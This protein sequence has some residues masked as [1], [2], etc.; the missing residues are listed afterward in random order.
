MNMQYK[1]GTG[2]VAAGT[3]VEVGP[4]GGIVDGGRTV[5]MKA[6]DKLPPTS[7][8]GNLWEKQ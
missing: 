2:N 7:K 5:S 4:R 6:G 3:Y 1:P 8:A